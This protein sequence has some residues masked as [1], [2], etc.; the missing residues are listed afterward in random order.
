MLPIVRREEVSEESDLISSITSTWMHGTTA[1]AALS[2]RQFFLTTLWL[3]L[4]SEMSTD[5]P[6]KGMEMTQTPRNNLL[7]K[8]IVEVVFFSFSY[9]CRVLR[10]QSRNFL[11]RP[12]TF[13]TSYVK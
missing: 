4:V 8:N 3:S 5:A 12:G 2:T 1:H 11:S 13:K 7:L 10:H 6:G 9:N